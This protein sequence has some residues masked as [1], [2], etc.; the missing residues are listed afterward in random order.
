MDGGLAEGGSAS[1]PSC[2]GTQDGKTANALG[3][4]PQTRSPLRTEAIGARRC[5]SVK[6]EATEVL[7]WPKLG[8]P[9]S[10]CRP[11]PQILLTSWPL[12]TSLGPYP[13]RALRSLGFPAHPQVEWT[14]ESCLL[15]SLLATFPTLLRSLHK[16]CRVRFGVELSSFSGGLKPSPGVANKV[17]HCPMF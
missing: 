8:A 6:V 14:Q 11:Q 13:T 7:P 1:E 15:L 9:N 16:P 2:N 4:V 17:G 12:N 5:S 3:N 10:S